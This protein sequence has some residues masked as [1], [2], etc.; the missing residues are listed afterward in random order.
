[1]APPNVGMQHQQQSE[2]GHASYD[3][4]PTPMGPMDPETALAQQQREEMEAK[5]LE[6]YS[7]L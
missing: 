6:F 1:M 3:P 7:N 2:G 5:D 4:N